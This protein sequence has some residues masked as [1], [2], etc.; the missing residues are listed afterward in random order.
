[1]SAWSASGMSAWYL[2][3][4]NSLRLLRLPSV[5]PETIEMP[6]TGTLLWNNVVWMP[7][8]KKLLIAMSAYYNNPEIH[9]AYMLDSADL[10][11]EPLKN[12]PQ[13]QSWYYATPSPNGRSIAFSRPCD[14][15][16]EIGGCVVDFV[17]GKR[18]VLKPAHLQSVSVLYWHPTQPWL[19]A[20]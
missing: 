20:I 7:D 3:A 10:K 11:L 14:L 6:V 17:S 12:G 18:V 15:A 19:F 2:D 8:S 4:S 1:Q 9:A 16:L 5:V 13:M